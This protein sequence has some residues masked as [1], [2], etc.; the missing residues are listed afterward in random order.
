[1]TVNPNDK[2]QTNPA[3]RLRI[4]FAKTAAMRYTSH[5]D[6]Y[7]TWE[8]TLRRAGLPLCYTQGFNPHPRVQLAAALPLGM[9]SSCELIDVWLGE[10]DLSK[11]K[12]D[13]QLKGS[14][15]PGIAIQSLEWVELHAPALQTQ[16]L[17]AEYTAQLLENT[18]DLVA[19]IEDLLAQSTLPR[20]RRE[21][22]YDLRPLIERLEIIQDENTPDQ[23][24]MC[25]KAQEG[26][27]GRP[28]EVLLA[29][30]ISPE[31]GRLE[32]TNIILA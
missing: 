2:Q 10:N 9:T 19:R 29:L 1:M 13:T 17:S 23:L 26:H 5:L 30:G 31:N 20:T 6:L 28:E 24:R 21:K 3:I 14:V 15:P 18:P 11:A 25:L 32:R 4:C 22:S 12:I 7:R 16:V 27:T 8:R